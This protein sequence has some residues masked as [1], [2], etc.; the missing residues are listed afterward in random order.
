VAPIMLLVSDAA[1]V[2]PQMAALE[3]EL[4]DQRLER[5]TH[6]A[7]NLASAGHLRS[8]ITVDEAGLIMWTLTSPS[9]YEF[10]VIRRG[11]SPKRFGAFTTAALTATLL[12][13]AETMGPGANQRPAGATR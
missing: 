9:L 7:R 3:A 12:P 8:D 11:W 13:P 10:L 4:D 1:A 2:D 5:M 6:N